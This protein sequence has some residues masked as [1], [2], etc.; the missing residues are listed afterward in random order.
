MIEQQICMKNTEINRIEKKKNHGQLTLP[1]VEKNAGEEGG[2]GAG[3]S[4][5]GTGRR[6]AGTGG[7]RRRHLP[8]VRAEAEGQRGGESS[9]A[10]GGRGAATSGGRHFVGEV[11]RTRGPEHMPEQRGRGRGRDLRRR[12]ERAAEAVDGG[13]R[14]VAEA[15]EAVEG[16]GGGGGRG[17]RGE[18]G[19]RRRLWDEFRR[20]KERD[21]RERGR[22]FWLGPPTFPECPERGHS[23]KVGW[24]LLRAYFQQALGK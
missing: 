14:W 10:S 9:T 22:R 7:P 1:E 4:G 21:G 8:W 17:R 19:G 13:R 24:G 6:G 23:G 15:G 2:D 12:R 20:R 11:R 3:G 18:G 16:G 5:P